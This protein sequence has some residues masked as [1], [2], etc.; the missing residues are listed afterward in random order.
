[1]EKIRAARL[2]KFIVYCVFAA[3]AVAMLLPVIYANISP[4]PEYRIISLDDG[5][6]FERNEVTAEDMPLEDILLSPLSENEALAISRKLAEGGIPSAC[7][8]L[9][10]QNVSIRAYLDGELIYHYGDTSISD[11]FVRKVHY[12]PLKEGYGDKTLSIT[13]MPG[14]N[15]RLK[16]IPDIC[17]GNK[18]DI[19]FSKLRKDSYPI[20]YGS[21]MTVYGIILMSAVLLMHKGNIRKLERILNGLILTASGFQI[22]LQTD[23]LFLAASASEVSLG[24]EA[25]LLIFT[26][27]AAAALILISFKKIMRMLGIGSKARAHDTD[28]I[29]CIMDL[30]PVFMS[31]I[32]LSGLFMDSF[33]SGLDDG[34]FLFN[35]TDRKSVV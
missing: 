14:K 20:F 24:L 9:E 13:L 12:I 17:L 27:A 22:L 19:F 23:L 6:S 3:A 35:L 30:L 1:M 15:T 10:L 18:S 5:W 25:G 33:F 28:K 8:A 16:D 29:G 7:V 2:I 31:V 4:D 32:L 26:A 34:G 11:I 21:F